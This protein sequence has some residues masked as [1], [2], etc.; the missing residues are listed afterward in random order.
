LGALSPVTLEALGGSPVAASSEDP[1]G[2]AGPIQVLWWR[3]IALYADALTAAGVPYVYIDGD[4]PAERFAGLRVLIAP[5][6][7]FASVERW[8]RLCAHAAEGGTVVFGPVIP[9]LDERMRPKPFEVPREGRQRR[10][11][12]PEEAAAVVAELV[13]ELHLEPRFPASPPPIETTVHEDEHGARVLFVIH[14]DTAP[15]QATVR[16][17]CAMILEDAMTGERFE[18]DDAV[19]I[20]MTPLSCRMLIVRRS[21][22][23]DRVRASAGGVG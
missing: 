12:R 9:S 20:T 10:V 18:G 11:D 4:A 19:R 6:Y 15:T 8:K 17:P 2:F 5:S 1:L 16:L 3:Q 7:E 21:A 13:R 23:E 14:P 22:A